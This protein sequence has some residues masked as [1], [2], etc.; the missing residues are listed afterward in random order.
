[1]SKTKRLE[2]ENQALK[3]VIA[4]IRE[5]LDEL[6]SREFSATVGR[7]SGIIKS[8]D[9]MIAFAVSRGYAIDYREHKEKEPDSSNCQG[10]IG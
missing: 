7:I 3:N 4:C 6:E 1:M 8:S 9:D 10:S 5:E 2:L